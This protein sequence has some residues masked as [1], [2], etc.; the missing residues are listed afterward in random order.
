MAFRGGRGRNDR[1][2][3]TGVVSALQE[4][5]IFMDNGYISSGLQVADIDG[6]GEKDC[7]SAD[8]PWTITVCI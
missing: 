2:G 5:N 6:N 4:D 1:R 3:S 7:F 8:P